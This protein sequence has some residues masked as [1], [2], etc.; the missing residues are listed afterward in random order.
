M[1]TEMRCLFVKEREVTGTSVWEGRRGEGEI[2]RWGNRLVK[3]KEAS[4]G[5][6]PSAWEWVEGPPGPHWPNRL[7]TGQNEG[8]RDTS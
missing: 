1:K 2:A 4:L 6:G 7:L 5:N 8:N 3:A